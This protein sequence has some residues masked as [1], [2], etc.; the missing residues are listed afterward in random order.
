MARAGL[1]ACFAKAV[2]NRQIRR[3]GVTGCGWLLVAVVAKY[4]GQMVGCRGEPRAESPHT[5]DP[6]A[7]DGYCLKRPRQNQD[8]NC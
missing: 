2:W 7:A 1:V 3:V 8:T 6:P 5:N 4:E